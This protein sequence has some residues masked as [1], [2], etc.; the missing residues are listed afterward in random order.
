MFNLI[1]A[2]LY[3][4]FKSKYCLI[5]AI[6]GVALALFVPL[7]QFVLKASISSIADAYG[8]QPNILFSALSCMQSSLN[9][10]S[11]YVFIV[12]IFIVLILLQ[13][14]I[15]GTIRN[16][17]ICGISRFKIYSTY[18]LVSSIFLLV[19]VLGNGLLTFLFS[20]PFFPAVPEGVVVSTFVG[21]FFLALL[22]DLIGYLFL[23]SAALISVS[24]FRTVGF[25]LLVFIGAQLGLQLLGSSLARAVAYLEAYE[26]NVEGI[27]TFMNVLNWINPFYLSSVISIAHYEGAD[28]AFNIVTPIVWCSVNLGLGYLATVKKD[29]K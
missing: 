11:I 3:R 9:P 27:I 21:H 4:F 16:K 12:S 20:L 5:L 28:L 24:L 22:F 26:T 6:V 1:K 23:A 10:G 15:N 8:V 25:A 14:Y 17:V 19:L 13:D 29:I 18:Y 7:L 2:E